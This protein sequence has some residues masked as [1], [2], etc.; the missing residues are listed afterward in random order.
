MHPARFG[1]RCGRNSGNNKGTAA[2]IDTKQSDV[3]TPV[4]DEKSAS[5]RLA[6]SFNGKQRYASDKSMACP[7]V[8]F[9]ISAIISRP[10][11]KNT[12]PEK[13]SVITR[14]TLNEADKGMLKICKAKT[15]YL[16][17]LQ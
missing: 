4:P 5:S 14:S 16:Q 8:F 11:R 15:L 7:H 6:F 2:V 9:R 3:F 13:C 17:I 1:T 10:F 12:S